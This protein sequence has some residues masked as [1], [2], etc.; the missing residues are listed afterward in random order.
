MPLDKYVDASLVLVPSGRKAGKAY[1]QIPTDGDGDLS[2]S[3]ASIKT[4]VDTS[5]N[6]VS[7]ADNVP[8][9]DFSL[10]ACPYLSLDPLSTNICLYS[11]DFG[12]TWATAAGA[13]VATDTTVSPGGSDDADTITL[14]GAVTSRVEQSITMS[15]STVYTLSV[16]AKVATGTKDFR[17]AYNDGSSTTASSD[18][19]AT[20][21]WQRFEFTFTTSASHT[22]EEIRITNNTGADPGDLIVW[23]A[24]LELGDYAT[25][26]IPTTSAAVTRQ[27]DAFSLTNLITNGLIGSTVGTMYIK[28][29]IN[30][31]AGNGS[32]FILSD[33]TTSN[34]IRITSDDIQCTTAGSS[35][36]ISNV[37]TA[38]SEGYDDVNFAVRWNGTNAKVYVDGTAAAAG[39]VAFTAGAALTQFELNGKND[40]SWI[41]EVLFYTTA[42]SD[43]DMITLTTP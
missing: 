40:T 19:T 26:Y 14:D 23:G 11:E 34:R 39:T 33:G 20:T 12:T 7:L 21:S 22:N 35:N 29:K 9:L 18:L 2:L 15:T 5:G 42:L 32:L 37:F 10:G 8:G 25:G 3:R 1:S 13:S 31:E 38:D 43:A 4:E 27:P 28:G 17:L 16:W 36:L 6:V 30:V 41:K 24:Q